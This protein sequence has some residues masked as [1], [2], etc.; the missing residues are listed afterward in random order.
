[1]CK[2]NLEVEQKAWEKKK[3]QDYPKVEVNSF[4][5]CCLKGEVVNNNRRKLNLG[6][7]LQIDTKELQRAYPLINI[8]STWIEY[9]DDWI[10]YFKNTEFGTVTAFYA[11]V[12]GEYKPMLIYDQSAMSTTCQDAF[13]KD[14]L[15]IFKELFELNV[16]KQ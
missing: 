4:D 10:V 16:Q 3:E 8:Q 1:M 13:G 5:A 6:W 9:P 15:K 2:K 12:K 11:K 14:R 7:L